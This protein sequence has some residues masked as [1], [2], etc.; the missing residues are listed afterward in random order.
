LDSHFLREVSQHRVKV[1]VDGFLALDL[2]PSAVELYGDIS[3]EDRGGFVALKYPEAS[4]LCE[5]LHLNGVST[6]SRG[7]ILRFGPA[8]YLSDRQL[9]DAIEMLGN[10][11]SEQLFT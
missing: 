7:N 5:Q 1:L 6:D 9:L 3:L 8:P 10:V 11:L 2:D 4:R